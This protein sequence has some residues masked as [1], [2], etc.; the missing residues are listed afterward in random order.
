MYTIHKSYLLVHFWFILLSYYSLVAAD[1]WTHGGRH[2]AY[3]LQEWSWD[4]GVDNGGGRGLGRQ[5]AGKGACLRLMVPRGHSISSIPL[6]ARDSLVTLGRKVTVGQCSVGPGSGTSSR[7]H[8][9]QWSFPSES[10]QSWRNRLYRTPVSM[11]LSSFFSLHNFTPSARTTFH[12]IFRPIVR[13][14][15]AWKYSSVRYWPSRLSSTRI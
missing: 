11:C 6:Q 14:T 2:A 12:F 1:R 4:D 15:L 7:A 10:P 8:F 13:T 5:Q 3:R 9:T